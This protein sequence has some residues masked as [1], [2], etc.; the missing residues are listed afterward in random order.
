MEKIKEKQKRSNNN[1]VGALP[2]ELIYVGDHLTDESSI[3]LIKYNDT[4]F[5]TQVI[6]DIKTSGVSF[7][8]DTVDWV[9]ITGFRDIDLIKD[10]GAFFKLHPLLIEDVLNTDHRPKIDEFDDYIFIITKVMF[11]NKEDNVISIEQLSM[12]L[13]ENW[14]IT[15]QERE[16]PFIDAIIKRIVEKKGIVRSKK[17]DYLL[18]LL[19]D[20][21]TDNYF[22]VTDQLGDVSEELEDKV[23]NSQTKNDLKRIQDFRYNI[24]LVRKNILPLREVVLALQK[25][26]KFINQDNVF[27]IRD[28]YE[29]IIQIYDNIDSLKDSSSS[30]MDLYMSGTSNK[31]NEIMKVL[32]IYS[33]LFIPLTFL[34]GIYG[35][36]FDIIPELHWEFGYLYFWI[37]SIASTLGMIVFFKYKKWL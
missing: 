24:K 3:Y 30:I 34:T 25:N 17:A 18:Y 15:Y 13:G 1:K 11:H 19:T 23:L 27:Y 22:V 10:V 4:D 12:I 28:V 8:H 26:I 9:K 31:M 32:T 5:D 14:L 16:Y 35:M 7:E 20:V 29:H 2:G 21:I 36:N 33:A 6:T 37:I